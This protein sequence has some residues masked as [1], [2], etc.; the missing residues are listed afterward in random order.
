MPMKRVKMAPTMI[1]MLIDD[2]INAELSKSL[3][4]AQQAEAAVLAACASAGFAATEIDVCIR[5]ASDAAQQALNRQWRNQD[6][7]TDVLSFPMQQAPCDPAEPLGDIALAVPFI[8]QEAARLDV[9]EHDHCLHLIVHATL[10][11]LSFDHLD[12]ADAKRM[13]QLEQQAMQLLAL[14]NPYPEQMETS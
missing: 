11:L 2:D 3:P 8:M 12:D 14:H 6:K 9:P 5:F 7:V 10:H 13:Q 1:D 4:S